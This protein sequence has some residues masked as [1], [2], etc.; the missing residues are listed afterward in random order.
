MASRVST[1]VSTTNAFTIGKP[2]PEQ[3]TRRD[4]IENQSLVENA[5][6]FGESPFRDALPF[7]GAQVDLEH[8]LAPQ[9]ELAAG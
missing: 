9:T 4:G 6:A 5:A 3:F 2:Q 7:P 8:I 1:P